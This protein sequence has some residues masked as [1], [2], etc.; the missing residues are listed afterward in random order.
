MAASKYSGL[1]EV[2]AKLADLQR[3]MG[4]FRS[5]IMD[6]RDIGTN[7]LTDAEY[8]F[9]LNASAEVRADRRKLSPFFQLYSHAK[10]II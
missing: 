9:Y 2:R 5:V 7:I 10:H 4:K 6:G 3:S 8:K 1:H